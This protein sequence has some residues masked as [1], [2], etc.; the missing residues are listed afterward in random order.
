[1]GGRNW[2]AVLILLG[3]FGW[4][5]CWGR[6]G[7]VNGKKVTGRAGCSEEYKKE[8]AC[9]RFFFYK[10]FPNL[11]TVF[12]QFANHLNSDQIL[13]FTQFYLQK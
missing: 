10:T 1:M 6:M 3:W 5:T 2:W 7:C 9:G 4:A 12:Y 11:Q 8:A 13:N